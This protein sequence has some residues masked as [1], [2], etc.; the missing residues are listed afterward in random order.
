VT[1]TLSPARP[2]KADLD[3]GTLVLTGKASGSSAVLSAQI[4]KVITGSTLETT[5]EGASTLTLTVTDW[6]R[7]LLQSPLLLGP[8]QMKF[9]G[10]DWTLTKIAKQGT[11]LTLTFED[12]AVHTLRQYRKPKKADRAHTTR[13]QFIR[14]MVQEV[15]EV[16]IP[17]VCPEI[18]D[19]QAIAKPKAQV[20]V[21]MQRW[22]L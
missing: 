14:S 21:G 1:S 9:D 18:N 17:F 11:I 15:K 3:V 2:P 20:R 5:I 22:H 4:Q 13:A 6:S 8:V 7:K 12:T 16:R 19:K 10:E